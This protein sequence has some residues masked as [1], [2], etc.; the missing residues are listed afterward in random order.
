MEEPDL[1]IISARDLLQAYDRIKRFIHR[2]PVLTSQAIN[3]LTGTR[4]YFKCE[5][6]QKVGAFKARGATNAVRQHLLRYPGQ[7]V[8]THSSGNHAQA[9]SWAAKVARLEAYVVMPSNSTPVKVKAVEGYGGRITFCVPTLEARETT[10]REVIRQTGATEIHPYNN[11]EIIAGQATAAMELLEDKTDLDIIMAPVGGGG[12]LSGTALASH[13]FRPGITVIGSEPAQADD[14]FRSF[15]AGSFIPSLNP[16]TM[17]DGLRTSLG[18]IT[19]PLIL[20][21]VN[22][23]FT[24]QEETIARAMRL[25]WER[26]K[27]IVEPSAAVPLAV[28][29]EEPSFFRDKQVGIILSGGNAD[30]DHLP[31]TI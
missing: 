23:I 16:Q 7:A 18:T 12:L 6:L 19:F 30:L 27:I 31:F 10:L 1:G 28:V 14:A 4:I 13:Y 24:V 20:K 26:M 15:R 29:M 5:N 17:A 8:A 11:P 9:L 22:D 2:T 25:I 21:Y 3:Q